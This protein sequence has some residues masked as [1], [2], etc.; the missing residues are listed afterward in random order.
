[1]YAVL[2]PARSAVCIVR[3]EGTV[4]KERWSETE[5]MRAALQIQVSDQGALSDTHFLCRRFQSCAT[6]RTQTCL[7]DKITGRAPVSK[8]AFTRSMYA[9]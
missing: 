9:L 2:Q 1:M 8:R 4:G 5:L 6:Q 7:T 3:T